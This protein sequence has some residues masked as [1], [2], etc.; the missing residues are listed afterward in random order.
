MARADN[1]ETHNPAKGQEN[2]GGPGALRGARVLGDIGNRMKKHLGTSQAQPGKPLGPMKATAKP[3]VG[4]S[5]ASAF[6]VPRLPKPAAQN[7]QENAKPQPQLTRSASMNQGTNKKTNVQNDAGV[8]V[9]GNLQNRSQSHI[10]LK[11]GI[12][13]S[14]NA[15]VGDKKKLPAQTVVYEDKL[16]QKEVSVPETSKSTEVQP[17][18]ACDA[19]TN[20]VF[21]ELKTESSSSD[22]TTSIKEN[23]EVA[24]FSGQ[25]FDVPDIDAEDGKNP[26]LLREYIQDICDYLFILEKKYPIK[27]RYLEGRLIN[28][29]MRAVLLDWLVEVHYQ[30]GFMPETLYMAAKTLDRYLQKERKV[31]RKQLQ[32]VG[33]TALYVAAKFEEVCTPTVI[34]FSAVS[35][36]AFSSTEVRHMEKEI[37]QSL[38]YDLAPPP[39]VFFL[40]RFSKAAGAPLLIHT[41]AKYIMEL[42]LVDYGTCHLYPSDQ[43]AAALALALLIIHKTKPLQELWNSALQHHTRLSLDALKPILTPVACML[44][45]V[46]EEPPKLKAVYSKYGRN[47]LN[48]ISL[49]PELQIKEW[50]DRVTRDLC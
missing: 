35:D 22:K 14:L 12:L 46:H 37:L 30:F 49:V 44:A 20:E 2:Q 18:E 29:K 5:K 16:Q 3:G 39:A 6:A 33:V 17:L 43:A 31:T 36:N 19:P 7:R 28:S 50:K 4:A 27:I 23:N 48:K 42:T 10:S 8:K 47:R 26:L 41:M 15:V 13:K 1:A 32:L 34:D 11:D 9:L 38:E 21:E 25:R 45:K 24:V 40:R